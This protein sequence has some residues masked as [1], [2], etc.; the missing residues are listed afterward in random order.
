MIKSVTCRQIRSFLNFHS[1]S[2]FLFFSDCFQRGELIS[3]IVCFYIQL[4]SS[5]CLPNDRALTWKS[6]IDKYTALR[7]SLVN[8]ILCIFAI[9]VPFSYHSIIIH[10][11]YFSYAVSNHFSTFFII[12]GRVPIFVN[13]LMF[14][15]SLIFVDNFHVATIEIQHC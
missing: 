7:L 10:N 6:L 1:S 12:F 2:I 4:R 11:M 5:C 14:P 13:R 15:T 9:Y 3:K 8:L